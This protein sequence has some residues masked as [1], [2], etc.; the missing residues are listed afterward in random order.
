MS[1]ANAILTPK[2]RLR[3]RGKA[4]RR[5]WISWTFPSHTCTTWGMPWIPNIHHFHR[6]RPGFGGVDVRA[7]DESG[8][9][10]DHHLAAEVLAPDRA[11]KLCN[12]PREH[13][14]RGGGD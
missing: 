8:M 11:R 14:S 12:I 4:R 1:H 7:D 6:Q 9:D 3:P 5:F 13:F 2:G 10:I